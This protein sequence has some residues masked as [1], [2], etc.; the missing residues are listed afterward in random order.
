MNHKLLPEAFQLVASLVLWR[1]VRYLAKQAFNA[2][3][4]SVADPL[5]KIFF[6]HTKAYAAKMGHKKLSPRKCDDCRESLMNT[7]N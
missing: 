5:V 4:N 3:F 1:V 6:E 7:P 2:Y